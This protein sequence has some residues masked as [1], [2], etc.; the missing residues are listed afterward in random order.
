MSVDLSGVWR[1]FPPDEINSVLPTEFLEIL[2]PLLDRE[3]DDIPLKDDKSEK[4]DIF[5]G[6]YVLGSV[7][8]THLTLPTKRIV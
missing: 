3:E 6:I 7:S 4:A 5:R 8:Y 2:E 1:R